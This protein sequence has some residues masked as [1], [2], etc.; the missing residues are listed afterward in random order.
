MKKYF[1]EKRTLF[2]TNNNKEIETAALFIFLNRTCFN[3]LYRV[4]AKGEFNVPHGKY[5]NPKICDADNLIA[6]SKILNRVEI[7]CGDFS[8]T[9]DYATKDTLFYFDPPYKPLSETSSFTSYS[10]IRFD[11]DEQIRLRDFCELISEKRS[12]FIVSNSDPT[13]VDLSDDFFDKI[14]IKFDIKR[15]TANRMINSVTTGRGKLN[16]VMISNIYKNN[17]MRNFD[18]WFNSFRETIADYKYYVDFDKVFKNVDSV[19]IELNILNSLIGSKNIED[20]FE[21]LINDY[22][23]VLKCIPIL[24]AKRELEISATDKEGSFVYNFKKMNHSI[25]QYKVFMRK[26]GLF[27][28]I[29]KHIV[30]NLFDYVTGVETGLSSNGR[31]NRGGDLMENLVEQ[32]LILSGF[33]KGKSYFK[34][35]TI[36]EIEAKWG[37]DLSCVSNGGKTVKRFDFVVKSEKCIYGIEANFYTSKGSK[38]NETARSYKN[39]ALETKD[40]DYFEFI[41]F[42]DGQGWNN[43]KNNLRETFDVLGNLYNI[44]DLENGIIDKVIK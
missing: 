3:G 23:N 43:A 33:E 10:S 41:W 16:E 19:K 40:L 14:Y 8:Q 26:T 24:I 27:E 1:L 7:L 34:E 12:L 6:V 37:I 20:D 32:F 11:D 25:E 39:I 35:M 22:P 36:K 15:V 30:S 38:L 13:Y 18:S 42:T 29:S 5:V 17:I 2:N 28:L 9:I 4:N 31:K 44:E 21:K